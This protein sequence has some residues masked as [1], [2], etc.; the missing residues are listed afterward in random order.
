ME[1]P[2]MKTGFDIT[3]EQRS[4][5]NEDDLMK[6]LDVFM[7]NA[8]VNAA[9]YSKASGRDNLSS[10]DMIYGMKYEAYVFCKNDTFM[11]YLEKYSRDSD[12]GSD[13]DSDSDSGSDS[14]SGSDNEEFTEAP[15]ESSELVRNMNEVNSFWEE[16]EPQNQVEVL[17]K[18]SIDD[19]ISA[20]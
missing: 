11:G 7:R 17:L 10:Q 4:L 3:M 18:K 19:T 6:L 12:S 1:F 9:M 20:Y 2:S 14:N 16:W 13:S 8:V 5:F 15:S